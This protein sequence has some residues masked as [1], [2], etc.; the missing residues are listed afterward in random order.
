[1]ANKYTDRVL[2]YLAQLTKSQLERGL[3]TYAVSPTP[4]LAL[5]STISTAEAK[6]ASRNFASSSRRRPRSRGRVFATRR[7]ASEGLPSLRRVARLDWRTC[8]SRSQPQ[9]EASSYTRV[10]SVSNTTKL[11]VRYAA[12]PRAC[13][14]ARSH[15]QIYMMKPK[16]ANWLGCTNTSCS[17]DRVDYICSLTAP[18]VNV[19]SWPE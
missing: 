17:V 9:A 8:R 12:S 2:P 1:M 3:I 15:F 19:V 5:D 7:R 18:A 6:R 4:S 11:S 16:R 14:S 10:R 13:M